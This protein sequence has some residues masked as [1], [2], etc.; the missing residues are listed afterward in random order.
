MNELLSKKQ[1]VQLGI[2]L[3]IIFYYYLWTAIPESNNFN[4]RNN[5]FNYY[6]KLTDAFLSG[7]LHLKQKPHSKLL[8]FQNPYDSGVD[9]KYKLWDASLY[10]GKYYVY[11][12]PAPALT[13]YIPY[14]ILFG[15]GLSDYLAVLIFMFGGVIWGTLILLLLRKKYFKSSPFW[16]LLLTVAVLGFSNVAPFNLRRLA[17]YQVAIAS[18]YFFVLGGLFFLCCAFQ[19]EKRRLFLLAS[20][21]LFFGSALGSRPVAAFT[22]FSLII[23]W[24]KLCK[25]DKQKIRANTVAI[26]VPFILCLFIWGIHNYLRFDNFFENGFR[27]QLTWID[28]RKLKPFDIHNLIPGTYL[29]IF[30]KPT[31]DKQFPFIHAYSTCPRGIPFPRLYYFEKIVGIF[32][33]VPFVLFLL[34]CPLIFLLQKSNRDVS[35]TNSNP[36]FPC[37]EFMII[38]LPGLLILTVYLFW[39][40]A[41]MRYVSDFISLIVLSSGIVFM[42]VDSVVR[43]GSFDWFFLRIFLFIFAGASIIIGAAFGIEGCE[44]DQD[45]YGLKRYRPAEF[46]RL[47]KIFQPVSKFIKPI[48]TH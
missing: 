11:F 8:E 10:K 6:N 40:A 19:N 47:E 46:R 35:K 22:V 27:Y 28:Q 13:L 25:E 30:H 37:S 38:L 34:I 26:V 4:P 7:Q 42:Y 44:M 41:L 9:R 29:Y 15:K 32:P 2:V 39:F 21:S 31:I 45:L 1:F 43:K 20:A 16:I 3:F 5:I 17:Q 36:V 23:I 18:G 14:R 48:T 33:S 12:G 24:L